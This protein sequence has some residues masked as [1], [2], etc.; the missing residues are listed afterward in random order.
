MNS[1][2]LFHRLLRL[3]AENAASEVDPTLP[4]LA[5]IGMLESDGLGCYRPRYAAYRL[6]GLWFVTDVPHRPESDSVFPLYP[7]SRFFVDHMRVPTGCSALDVCTGCG[8]YAAIAATSARNVTAVDINPRALSFAGYNLL[9]NGLRDHVELVQGDLMGPL[10]GEMFDYISANPPFEPTPPGA[11]NYLHSD[12]GQDGLIVVRRLLEALPAALKDGGVFEMV[13]FSLADS[14]KRL[15]TE[16]CP[17]PDGCYATASVVFPSL[18]L[19]KFAERFDSPQSAVWL[20]RWS[21]I[22][23]DRLCLLYVRVEK[24]YNKARSAG[25]QTDDLLM[26]SVGELDWTIPDNDIP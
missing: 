16:E 23:Y 3:C 17:A 2:V 10:H 18:P 13:S 5:K 12:G 9:L 1:P 26:S 21:A 6:R 25:W 14:Q 4:E 11:F 7:E 8:L 19:A 20:N 24:G 22:G 15:L